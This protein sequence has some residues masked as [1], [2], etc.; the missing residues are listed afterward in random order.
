[1]DRGIT[2]AP[3]FAINAGGIINVYKEYLG[4]YNR[5]DAYRTAEKIYDTCLNIQQL[6]ESNKISPQEAAME[7]ALDRIDKIGQVKLSI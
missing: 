1:M 3:D 2:Y 7:L 5:D 4:S 6:S